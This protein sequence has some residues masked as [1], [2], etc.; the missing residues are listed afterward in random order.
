MNIA[1]I[2]TYPPRQCG[3]AT[4]TQDLF[5]SLVNIPQCKPKI[6]A[7]SDESEDFFPVEVEN[8]IQKNVLNS[9]EEMATYINYNFDCVIIQ[10]EYGIF[11]GECGNYIVRLAAKIRIPLFTNFHTVL[12]HPSF[13]ENRILQALAQYS[14]TVTVMT[15][16][17]VRMLRQ[18]YHVQESKI[19]LIPHGVPHFYHSQVDAKQ[20]LGL[21]DKKVMLS[22]GFLGPSK[23]F[24][25]AIE[26]T[27]A[28]D[29]DDFVYIILGSTHPNILR[30]AGESYRESLQQRAEELGITDKVQLINSFAS[31]EL[32]VQY[33]SACDIYVTPYPNESQIS[34]GTLSFAIGAGA[35]VISTPYLY[36][37]DL[38][39]DERGLLFDFK[40]SAGLAHLVNDLLSRP[41][42]LLKYRNNAAQYG[43][44]MSWENVG[45]LQFDMLKSS[46][47][48]QDKKETLKLDSTRN[49]S[50][51][52]QAATHKL[53]S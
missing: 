6:I 35:A 37:K 10:H 30:E 49:V 34:S 48:G 3:I 44:H 32:L 21:S 29:H 18:V 52:I 9:Y 11:G 4:F 19:S 20:S 16:T 15:E 14:Y 47:T 41:E 38:L 46:A 33:L 5:K 43:K 40:D 17:A 42:L 53:S 22:F 28:I 24:E 50:S 7:V 31:E 8:I 1:I 12:Q 2:G 45:K 23:G 13:E 51:L 26:A 25:T 39:K 36:A 27:S